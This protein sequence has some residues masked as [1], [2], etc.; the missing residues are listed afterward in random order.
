[1]LHDPILEDLTGNPRCKEIKIWK[2]RGPPEPETEAAIPE[3]GG[4]P[5]AEGRAEA[6]LESETH[7]AAV[8]LVAGVS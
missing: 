8:S 1:M 2:V 7:C 4:I 5:A 6:P 3:D